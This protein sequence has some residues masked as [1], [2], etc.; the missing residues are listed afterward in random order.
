MPGGMGDLS[1]VTQPVWEAPIPEATLIVV[2]DA[3]GSMGGVERVETMGYLKEWY[4]ET[5]QA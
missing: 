5:G 2:Y 3:V 1:G 4:S